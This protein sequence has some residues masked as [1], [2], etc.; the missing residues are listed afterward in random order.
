MIRGL[1][2]KKVYAPSEWTVLMVGEAGI[3]EQEFPGEEFHHP[4]RI[5]WKAEETPDMPRGTVNDVYYLYHLNK[6]KKIAL[7]FKHKT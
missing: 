4:E 2:K 6:D 5:F 1:F 3:T 7:Y